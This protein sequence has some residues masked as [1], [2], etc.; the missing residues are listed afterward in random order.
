MEDDD[1]EY[2]VV[3]NGE[4]QYSIWLAKKPDLP[5]GWS[6]V[7]FRGPKDRCLAVIKETWIDMRP[8]SLR[9]HSDPTNSPDPANPPVGMPGG[10]AN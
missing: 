9:R 7:G 1:R 4:Q 3:V 8:L 5:D 6:K 10:G 2:E